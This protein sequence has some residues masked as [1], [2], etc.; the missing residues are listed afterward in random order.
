NSN[1]NTQQLARAIEP[2]VYLGDARAVPLEDQSCDLI[3]T[4]PPY[5]NNIDYSK[6]YGLELS[7]LNMDKTEAEVMRNRAIRSFITKKINKPNESDEMPPEVGEIGSR[8]P[9]IGTYFKDMELA[10]KEM[11]RILRSGG[12]ANVIVSNSVIHETHV[13]VDEVFAEMAER[14]GFKE[15]EIIVGAQRI[16]DVKPHKVKTRESIVVMRK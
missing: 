5:L 13:L 11:H 7:L 8:I 14:I 2:E 1:K 4:S 9:I 6:I 10:I 15:I 12:T 16:A 3:I